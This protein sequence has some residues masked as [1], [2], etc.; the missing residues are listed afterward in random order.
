VR[1]TVER[2]GK[3]AVVDVTDDLETVRVGDR[4]YPLKIVSRGPGK[5]ELEIG[6]EAVVVAGWP[7]HNAAPTGPVDV[8][9]E[10]WTV[11]VKA[12]TLPGLAA[13]RPPPPPTPSGP[14]A[15]SGPGPAVVA[16]P[17]ST[18]IVP[19]MPGRVVE[20]KVHEGQ[21][22]TKGTVLLILE[23]MKMRNE[24]TAP[25]DGVVHELRVHEGTNV[26]AR[27]TM[28]VLAPK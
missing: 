10:R 15:V 22:V 17:G 26:R 14:A 23:A 7:E 5:V 4:S 12:E 19:P 13:A 2:G 25:V 21:A 27:E 16:P 1:L 3:V 11:A 24:V 20:V 9:G 6:G 18:P 28:L 8:N